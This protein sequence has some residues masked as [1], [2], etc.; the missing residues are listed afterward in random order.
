M[1]STAFLAALTL[2]VVPVIVQA[3]E[4]LNERQC[5]T[6]IQARNWPDA[7]VYCRAAA[8]DYAVIAQG[9]QGQQR[10]LDLMREGISMAQVSTAYG[11]MGYFHYAA[12]AE[13]AAR[14]FLTDA[15]T[16][17]DDPQLLD[18]LQWAL[19]RL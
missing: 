9:H 17:T 18:L 15:T 5:N 7:A 4:F 13:T 12:S 3:D 11:K 6:A 2:I 1:K 19:S 10:A 16:Q 8:D 14:F